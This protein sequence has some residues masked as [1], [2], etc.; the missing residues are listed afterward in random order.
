MCGIFAYFSKL[1]SFASDKELTNKLIKCFNLIQHRGPDFSKHVVF[2]SENN[3]AFIGFHRLSIN[4]L[5]DVGNQPF[6]YTGDNSTLTHLV[7]NGEIYNW[8]ELTGIHDI[9]LKSNSDCEVIGHLLNSKQYDTKTFMNMLDG[10][11]SCITFNEKDYS[12]VVFRDSIGIRPLFYSETDDFIAFASEGKALYPLHHEVQ[13]F[14]PG[15]YWSNKNNNISFHQYSSLIPTTISFCN[16]TYN[17]RFSY[18]TLQHLVIQAVE[19][20]ITNCDTEVG[21]F[22]SGGLDSS[23][24]AS[25]AQNYYDKHNIDKK[26]VTFSIGMHG[27]NSSDL[28]A[29]SYIAKKLGSDHHHVTYTEKEAF[30]ALQDVIHQLESYD[31]TTIRASIPMY[32][33]C[34]YISQKTHT[35]VL[36]SGEGADEVFGG[37]LYFHNHP[38]HEEFQNETY[39]LSQ[40]VHMFDVLRA[41][42]CNAKWGLEVRVPFFDHNLIEYV[43]NTIP[44]AKVPHEHANNF[45][46]IE[47]HALRKA[48]ENY[49]Y[50]HKIPDTNEY[51]YILYRQKDAFSDA[52]G[53]SWVSKLK[54]HA[55][56]NV[57]KSLKNYEIDQPLSN[58]E[59]YYRQVFDARYPNAKHIGN[60]GIWRPNW[61]TVTDP[62][63]TQLNVHSNNILSTRN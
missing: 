1:N 29:A 41:D 47:K 37:Y 16:R 7:C 27:Q 45:K 32:L 57:Q 12:S 2:T 24:V 49:P 20:R 35:K 48:F 39:K 56:K 14:P 26:I 10:E 11:F 15:Y 58:E 63:A 33:L 25:I 30:N 60:I 22:L 40:K 55:E 31:C 54:K 44:I 52:V 43:Y 28:Y 5:S 62:S 23:I 34:K 19:K 53:Y 38:T 9:T 8:K 3:Y 46:K 51:N 21:F 50:I 36:L 18:H 13:I 59:L 61:T 4:D 42:R 6:K 17:K